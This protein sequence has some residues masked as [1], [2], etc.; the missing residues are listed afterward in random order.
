MNV[1][2]PGTSEKEGITL[3]RRRTGLR[4][5]SVLILFVSLIFTAA[6]A[7]YPAQ[8]KP[9]PTSASA[10]EKASSQAAVGQRSFESH[11]ASCHGLDGR[12]GE[13]AHAIAT[14]RAAGALEDPALSQIIRGGIPSQGM[15]SFGS[16]SE[17]EIHAI[18]TYLRLLTGK[19]TVRPGKGNSVRGERLFFGKARCGDCHMMLGK[20]GFIGSD[21]TGFAG[22]HSAGDLRRAIINPDQWISP[23]R[24]VVTVTTLSQERV[25]GLVRNQDNF[26]LQV[27]DADG[28]FHLFLTSQIAKVDREPHSLMP[29]DY[30]T[31][32]TPAELDDLI[33]FLFGGVPARAPGSTGAGPSARR[34]APKK[35]LKPE[36]N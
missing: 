6:L 26:S 17:P 12:G 16:L 4:G 10:G 14:P 21:L 32:L 19:S 31:R 27:Q 8:K 29:E 9:E 36:S 7:T 23:A 3:C 15:P 24:N 11:C 13:H 28:V 22:S 34:Q 35:P 18:I 2:G 33:S 25:T 5:R 20:G 30:G 1:S